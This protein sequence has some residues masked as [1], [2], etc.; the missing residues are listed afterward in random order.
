MLVEA[1]ILIIEILK[2]FEEVVRLNAEA[3]RAIC[4]SRDSVITQQI[5]HPNHNK[6]H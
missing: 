5:K 4:R 2:V 1:M 3:V 6:V